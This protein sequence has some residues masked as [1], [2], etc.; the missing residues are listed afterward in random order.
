MGS[1]GIVLELLA[2]VL[3]LF[4]IGLDLRRIARALEKLASIKQKDQEKE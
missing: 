1:N 2:V 3:V 4:G